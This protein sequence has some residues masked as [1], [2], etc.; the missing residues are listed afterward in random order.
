MLVC[1]SAINVCSVE[2]M[3]HDANEVHSVYETEYKAV[4]AA[5]AESKEHLE[6]VKA[7]TASG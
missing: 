2:K 5:L 1:H 4:S 6:Q 3:A 7:E